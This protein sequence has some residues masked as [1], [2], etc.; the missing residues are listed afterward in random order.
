M[1]GLFYVLRGG[2]PWR[3]LPRGEFAPMTTV[4]HYFYAWR[5][6]GLWQSLNH[7]LLMGVR[8]ACGKGA[9]P[10]AGV[11]DSQSVK[12]TDPQGRAAQAA[13]FAGLTRVKKSKGASAISLLIPMDFWWAASFTEPMCKTATA[14]ND[15]FRSQP[16]FQENETRSSPQIHPIHLPMAASYLRRRGLCRQEFARRFEGK[17]QLDVRDRQTL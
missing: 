8:E 7:Y 13:V 9:S 2:L 5:D 14:L 11:I 17:R 10:T 12:T 4:W 1:N 16:R 3:M 15:K 6:S